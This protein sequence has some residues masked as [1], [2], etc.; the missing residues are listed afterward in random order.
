MTPKEL[1]HFK[2]CEAREWT[3]RYKAKRQTIG[4]SKALLWWQGV[5][6]DLQ[7]IRGESD[8]LDLRQRMNRIQNETSSKG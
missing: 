3:R 4:S 1:E 6:L 8:T 2:D 7:R 5:L